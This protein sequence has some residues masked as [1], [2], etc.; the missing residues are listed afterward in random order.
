MSTFWLENS[1]V[2]EIIVEVWTLEKSITT[3]KEQITLKIV[4]SWFSKKGIFR[5]RSLYQGYQ[6]SNECYC[7]IVIC[8]ASRLAGLATN[9]YCVKGIS[10]NQ[11]DGNDPDKI[12]QGKTSFLVSYT[13]LTIFYQFDVL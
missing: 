7:I 13:Y 5:F 10:C 11:T 9:T 8:N 12:R 4:Q 1:N 2:V 3:Y 6:F